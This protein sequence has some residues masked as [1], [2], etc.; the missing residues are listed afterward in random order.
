MEKK[1]TE[2]LIKAV[3][4]QDSYYAHAAAASKISDHAGLGKIAAIAKGAKTILEIGCGEGSKLAKIGPK[5]SKLFG[6][7]ISKKAIEIGKRKYP[8]INFN[9]G[10]IENLSYDSNLFDFT[11]QT[12]VLEHLENPEKV[13]LEQTRVTKK[14]GKLIF[15]APNFGAPNR[16]SPCFIGKR[17]TKLILG[18]LADLL[19]LFV[20]PKSLNWLK[21][22]PRIG[23]AY[24][25]D[26]DTQVEPYLLILK[27]FLETKGIRVLKVNSFWEMEL[28]KANFLQIILRFLGEKL[29]VYPFTYWGPHLFLIGEKK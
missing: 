12:F 13:I 20:V 5:G 26:Y 7:D 2:T 11:Y 1:T 16:A 15:I 18:F 17:I 19:H 4:S 6:I 27:K 8:K 29:K 10:N 9:L 24:Q 21:V 23:E 28:P 3:W 22:K 25:I 14:G